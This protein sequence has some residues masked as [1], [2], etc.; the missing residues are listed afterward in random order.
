MKQVSEDGELLGAWQDG[1]AERLDVFKAASAPMRQRARQGIAMV[2]ADVVYEHDVDDVVYDAFLE[3]ERIGPAGVKSLIGFA[4]T[5]AYRRGQD[6]GRA[7]IRERERMRDLVIDLGVTADPQFAED[8]VREAAEQEVLLQVAL[9]C[10]KGLTDEQRAVVHETIMNRTT[11]SDWALQTG[12]SY[13]SV[14]RQRDR[15]LD[16]LRRCVNRKRSPDH[17]GANDER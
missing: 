8:D 12:R 9:E 13:Q 1:R 14:G 15:A 5:I 17:E 10:M 6:A 16:A 7:I 3:L 11:L 2:T 4:K